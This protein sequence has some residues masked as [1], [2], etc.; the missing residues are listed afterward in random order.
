MQ[1]IDEVY[2]YVYVHI[3]KINKKAYVGQTI[4]APEKR[5]ANGKGYIES[6]YFYNAIQK[7]GWNNFEHIILE[8]GLFT[9]E[10]LNNKEKYWI[11][12][13]DSLNNG[14]NLREGGNNSKLTEEHKT[15]IQHSNAQTLGRPVIC[16][17]T[18]VIYESVNAAKRDTGAEH[19]ESCCNG[20][21]KSAGKDAQGNALIWKYVKDYTGKEIETW[22]YWAPADPVGSLF[23]GIG[24]EGYLNGELNPITKGYYYGWKTAIKI[25]AYDSNGKLIEIGTVASGLTDEL[26]KDF[27]VN[28]DKYLNKVVMLQCMELDKKEHT[29]RHAFFKGFRDDKNAT[30]C[31]IESIFG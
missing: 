4:Q 1:I 15:K 3:N 18:G 11:S 23:K 19:I 16:L 10:E 14:Y 26:R 7:Y 30:E 27:A 5:W 29:L 20:I 2:G 13:Y 17:N 31:T 24:Y 12:F 9:L 6:T 8:E 22:E 25:G 28:P 21:L